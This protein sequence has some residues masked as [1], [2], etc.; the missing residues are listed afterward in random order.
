M[1]VRNSTRLPALRFLVFCNILHIIMYM[2]GLSLLIEST[3]FL[4]NHIHLTKN[5]GPSSQNPCGRS[6]KLLFFMDF[7]AERT[8]AEE[9]LTSQVHQKDTEIQQQVAQ[10]QEKEIQIHQREAELR[11]VR[12]QLQQKD[13]ELNHIQQSFEVLYVSIPYSLKLSKL[14][15]FAG[16]SAAVKIFSHKSS[17]SQQMQG[18]A[19]SLTM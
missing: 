6:E 17:K 10:L 12:T 16:L 19:G 1:K 7:Q 8:R 2:S 15:S 3:D 9:N 11:Q 13:T 18:V 4:I 5:K 14:K